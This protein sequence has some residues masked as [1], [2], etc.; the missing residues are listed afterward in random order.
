MGQDPAL[1][2]DMSTPGARGSARQGTG[3]GSS[4]MWTPIQAARSSGLPL[5]QDII[6]M[7]L[8]SKYCYFDILSHFMY[9]RTHT[10]WFASIYL[11]FFKLIVFFL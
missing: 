6:L 9:S 2:T 11:E 3:G 4:A 10:M 8:V 5:G 7:R 1:V